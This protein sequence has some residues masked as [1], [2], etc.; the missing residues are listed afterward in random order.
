MPF[1]STAT[2]KA[3]SQLFKGRSGPFAFIDLEAFDANAAALIPRAGGKTIRLASKSIR[4]I[5]LLRRAL[6]SHPQYQGVMCYSPLEAAF[7]AEEGF[8]DLLVAYPTLNIQGLTK[9][10]SLIEKGHSIT[11]MVDREEHLTPLEMLAQAH[12]IRFLVCLELDVSQDYP[13]LRFGSYRSAL[14]SVDD[15]LALAKRIQQSH[16]L[17]L[18]GLM[19]Y[20]GQVAGLGD[21]SSDPKARAIAW[22]KQKAIPDIAQRRTAVIQ[23]L[24]QAGHTLRFVNG[25]G[26]GSLESTSAEELVTEVAMGSGLY[27]PTL[28]DYYQGFQHQPAAGFALT[29]TRKPT[30]DIVTCHG[31]GY[32]ASGAVGANRLP[33]PCFPAGL[34]LIPNEGAGE[35]QTPLKVPP[36]LSLNIGDLI[37]FRHAKA[38]ELCEH[39]NELHAVQNS[40][41]IGAFKTYRGEGQVF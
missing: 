29:V 24:K 3:F 14:Q 16:Y 8:D 20:E 22:L 5:E 33:T 32:I 11:L 28:F 25:G 7:L 35:V 13:G 15:V 37:F 40:Q 36:E 12:G 38:G 4:C 17:Q 27:S 26:T 34:K 31:G 23:A 9:L 21:A 2:W 19:A 10:A 18:D 30:H 6:N 41:L 1:Q 39:F